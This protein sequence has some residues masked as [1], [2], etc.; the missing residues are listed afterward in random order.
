MTTDE[1]TETL[2][3]DRLEAR[4]IATLTPIIDV[5]KTDKELERTMKDVHVIL[6]KELRSVFRA[7]VGDSEY[8]RKLSMRRAVERFGGNC[9]T[10]AHWDMFDPQCKPQDKEVLGCS[11]YAPKRSHKKK[12]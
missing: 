10:C 3:I 6:A 9:R 5:R 4:I 2:E 12:E 8:M 11:N 1:E 7:R